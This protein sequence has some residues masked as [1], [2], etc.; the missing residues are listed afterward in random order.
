MFLASANRN[1]KYM[2]RLIGFR[3]SLVGLDLFLAPVRNC[4]D[5]AWCDPAYSFDIA[6]SDGAIV[7][8]RELIELPCVVPKKQHCKKRKRY[9]A[10]KMREQQESRLCRI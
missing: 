1:F 6:V 7:R 3:K 10:A 2:N 4:H 5:A 8:S 9:R